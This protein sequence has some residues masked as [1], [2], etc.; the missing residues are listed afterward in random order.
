MPCKNRF[1]DTSSKLLALAFLHD[2]FSAVLARK[3]K[4]LDS[5]RW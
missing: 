4:G 2:E 3:G 1:D 5:I